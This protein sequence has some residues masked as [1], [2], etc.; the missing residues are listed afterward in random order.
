MPSRFIHVDTNGRGSLLCNGW[1]VFHCEYIYIYI[2]LL[3]WLSG[4]ESACWYIRWVQTLSQKDTLEKE[5]ATHSSILA[6]KIPW[7]EEP[8]RLQSIGLQNSWTWLSNYTR[9]TTTMCVCVL[10]IHPLMDR[11]MLFQW[12]ILYN[13]VLLLVSY[14]YAIYRCMHVHTCANTHT[15][16]CLYLLDQL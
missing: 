11:N 8:C 2:Y 5:M 6:W 1:V 9:I 10:H 7:T 14:M 15:F 13:W 3:W 16:S 4:K 12:N